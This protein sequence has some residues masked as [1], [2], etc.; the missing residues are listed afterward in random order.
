M[1]V[2]HLLQNFG[3][4]CFSICTRKL[5]IEPWSEKLVSSSKVLKIE[6]PDLISLTPHKTK[7]HISIIYVNELGLV[8]LLTFGKES[9][10]AC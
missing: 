1:G 6:Y 3:E 2:C 7:L 8:L 4:Q 5:P 9:I 10:T